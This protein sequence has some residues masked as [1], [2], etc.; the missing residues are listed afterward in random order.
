MKYKGPFIIPFSCVCVFFTYSFHE[1]NVIGTR[2]FTYQ[3]HSLK[4]E[5]ADLGWPT[6]ISNSNWNRIFISNNWSFWI[7]NLY[8]YLLF[9]AAYCYGRESLLN[10]C[11]LI[12]GDALLYSMFREN[13]V[14]I[15]CPFRGPFTFTYNRGYGECRS[16]VSSIDI[17]TEDSKLLVSYQACP[18]VH[19][20]ESASK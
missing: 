19:G 15:P 5:T 7:W 14:A 4:L 11:G 10:L 18:D 6:A 9:S 2:K 8:V 1:Q 17:C 20:S 12:T 16:P 3:R 13:A